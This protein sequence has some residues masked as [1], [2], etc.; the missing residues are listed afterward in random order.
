MVVAA[1]VVLAVRARILL[2]RTGPGRS[3]GGCARGGRLWDRGSVHGHPGPIVRRA[4]A[5]RHRHRRRFCRGPGRSVHPLRVRRLQRGRGRRHGAHRH[6]QAPRARPRHRHR[7]RRL[8]GTGGPVPL[9]G[10]DQLEHHWRHRE[11]A[12]RVDLHLA[13]R[14]HDPHGRPR[15][16]LGRAD[17]RLVPAPPPQLRELRAGRGAP[18]ARSPGGRG[19]PPSPGSGGVDVG[20]HDRG[21]PLDG[22]LDRAGSHRSSRRR[23]EPGSPSRWPPRSA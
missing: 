12:L 15:R 9:R 18:S 16:R 6:P 23:P 13:A 22:P 7:A 2:L 4:R 11:R 19:L 10:H 14:H 20:D 1:L 17:R 3:G 21:D 5:L 8:A